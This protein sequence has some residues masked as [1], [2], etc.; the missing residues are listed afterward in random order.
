ML[1]KNINYIFD[2]KVENLNIKNSFNISAVIE[3][4]TNTKYGQ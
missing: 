1:N 2:N 3:K 4:V